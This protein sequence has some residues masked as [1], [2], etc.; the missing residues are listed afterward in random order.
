VTGDDISLE[1]DI[2]GGQCGWPK[3]QKTQGQK[4]ALNQLVRPIWRIK[5]GE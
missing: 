3:K 1:Y 5:V 4:E 2:H